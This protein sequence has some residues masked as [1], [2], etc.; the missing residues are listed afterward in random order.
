[1]MKSLNIG[2]YIPEL[3]GHENTGSF[4]F[5]NNL[6][7][8]LSAQDQQTKNNIFVI[9]EN[10]KLVSDL[11]GKNLKV[12]PLPALIVKANP[13][14]LNIWR[15]RIGSWVKKIF[16]FFY[17][18]MEF[19]S[20]SVKFSNRYYSTSEKPYR[21]EELIDNH[22]IDLMI[23]ANQFEIPTM[24]RPYI[25]I[26]WDLG[27]KTINFFHQIEQSHAIQEKL[28]NN[29]SNA[30]RII[31]GSKEGAL[32]ISKYL[33]FPSERIRTISFPVPSDLLS[34]KSICPNQELKPY[35]F[36]P[37]LLT[38][39]K[40]H[41]VIL[42][43]LK[44][45]HDWK[46]PLHFVMSGVNKDNLEHILHL[47]K[48]LGIENF[49]H[50]LGTVSLEELKGLYQNAEA[51]VFPSLLG[52]NNF[53][54]IEAMALGVPCIASNI[55]GHL[56]QLEDNALFFDPLYPKSLA[57]KVDKLINDSTLRRKLIKK[58]NDFTNNL[59]PIKYVEELLECAE[60]F[61]PYKKNWSKFRNF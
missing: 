48:E 13:S 2:F 31:S 39:F 44:L 47:A 45:L 8:S 4:T 15:F 57:D 37:A 29:A 55:K 46:Q 12:L 49:V 34:C 19:S 28:T 7:Q 24:C 27:C 58:G 14:Y 33:N 3:D 40:N 5:L 9:C 60:E 52:P 20:D 17:L 59:T 54:P 10:I 23:Y 16:N 26:L 50:Y 35:L 1:M 36:Y 18:S 25:W 43:A 30:F 51:M 32:E 38:P 56:D 61:L 6:V 42:E 11:K 53:P 22:E 21:L 41:A